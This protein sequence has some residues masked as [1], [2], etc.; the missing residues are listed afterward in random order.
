MS[1]TPRYAVRKPA[2]RPTNDSTERG[3]AMI[4]LL[5]TV[6]IVTLISVSLVG[7][8]NTDMRHASIQYAVARS[9]YIAQA[10]LEEAKAQFFAAA[11]P[12]LYAT[13]AEGVTEAYGSGRFTYWVGADS[14]AGCGMGLETLEAV[15]EVPYLNRTFSTR[16]RACGVPGAP[17]L[18]AL[19]GVG[20]VRLQGAAT[21]LYLA[22]YLTGA[23]GGGGSLGSFTEINFSD[24]NVR[25][26]AINDAFSETLTLRDGRFLDYM[27][28]G[29]PSA[30]RYDPSPTDDP[31]PWILPVFG[32][33]IKAQ[34]ATGL[35]PNAC[36]TSYACVTAGNSLTDIDR[37]SDLR[38]ANYARH[39]Y[40]NRMREETLPRLALASTLFRGQAAQN[41]GN[42][43]INKA[44]RFPRPGSVY[45]PQQFYQ[46]V[47]YLAADPTKSLQGTV[48]VDGS[49]L[50]SQSVELGNVTLVV[51]GDLIID[52]DVHIT[53]RHDLSTASGRRAPGIM[54]FGSLAPSAAPVNECEEQLNRTGRLVLC[55]GSTLTVDGLVYTRDGMAV[56]PRAL[57]DQVGA[58]YH[59]TGGTGNDSFSVRD[60]TVVLRFDP[61]ALSAF[62]KG[63]AILSWQQVR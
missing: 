51:A 49:V 21:R 46:I 30:P 22:P 10:G 19:F 41:T 17:F 29:F 9:F 55:N 5:V 26:N 34:P 18:S 16:V 54:V 59:D 63:I 11:D 31:V 13:P 48:F 36:G 35:A 8:M 62:G 20:R 53:I 56:H 60:A 23:P 15:G 39:V 4:T 33:I 40:M 27:L 32:D 12:T 3:L 57:V 25:V 44:L 45:A 28:F 38:G 43:A 1:A 58:M 61:L 6:M 47:A 42:A 24:N 37:I 14:G 50:V 52:K 2:P 7:F